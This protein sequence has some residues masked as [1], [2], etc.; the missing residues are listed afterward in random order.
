MKSKAFPTRRAESCRDDQEEELA[1]AS[2]RRVEIRTK[3]QTGQAEIN[4]RERRRGGC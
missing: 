1:K 4:G 2:E 3:E